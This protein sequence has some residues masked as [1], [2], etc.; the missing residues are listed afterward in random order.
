MEENLHSLPDYPLTVAISSMRA[1]EIAT[2][3][4]AHAST[5]EAPLTIVGWLW[6]G[7][8]YTPARAN[9]W[10]RMLHRHLTI[11]HRF[12]LL[13][14]QPDANYDR[15]I[16]P[17]PL[18]DDWR[19]L[20]NREWG[21]RKAQCYVR[22]KAFSP[23]VEEILGRRF[24]SVDLD[25]V[26]LGN[27]DP[28]F[29]RDEDFV[30]YR[31]PV[32]MVP[33]DLENPYQCSMWMM[34]T[35]ARRQVWD[36]F[37][38]GESVRAAQKFMGTDQAWLHHVLSHDEASWDQSSGVYSWPKLREDPAFKRNPPKDARIIFFHGNQKP[39][40]FASINQPRCENCGEAFH[41]KPPYELM[42]NRRGADDSYQWI[43]EN[44]H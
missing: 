9:T 34:T 37:K 4:T 40:H 43:P 17:V 15:L 19:D 38:G 7:G 25:C 16:E 24:V 10:A 32:L 23:E 20:V 5:T 29:T 33:L 6:K 41:V 12:V 26:V 22:L 1:R 2:V 8:E 18:W 44:Y 42:R 13:T 28:L 31:R 39:W 3:M 36:K 14:D 30:I 35:G 11:P 27:L 21:A